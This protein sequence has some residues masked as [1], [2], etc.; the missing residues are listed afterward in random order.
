MVVWLRQLS[1]GL[2]QL[3]VWSVTSDFEALQGRPVDGRSSG[4]VGQLGTGRHRQGP[5]PHPCAV[6]RDEERGLA[7][8]ARTCAQMHRRVASEVTSGSCSGYRLD[9]P[10][11]QFDVRSCKRSWKVSAGSGLIDVQPRSDCT[12]LFQLPIPPQKSFCNSSSNAP[13]FVFLRRNNRIG[14]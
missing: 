5:P 1:H 12:S 9:A 3:I 8:E 7:G 10:S 13:R 14:V 4:G 2:D 11:E 6:P